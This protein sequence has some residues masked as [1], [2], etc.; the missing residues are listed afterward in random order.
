MP[1]EA[2]GTSQLPVTSSHPTGSGRQRTFAFALLPLLIHCSPAIADDNVLLQ[3]NAAFLQ[4]V[5]NTRLPPPQV[6]RAAAILHTCTYDAW[7]AYDRRALGTRFGGALRRPR[8][9]R[10]EANKS[11]AISF[12][13][14]RALGDLFPTQRTSVFDPLLASL[15][16]EAAPRSVDSRSP[17]YIG[18]LACKAVLDLRHADGANQLGD[19][20]P[21]AYSDYT[22]YRPINDASRLYDPNRWQPLLQSNGT[23]Q[24][25]L[26]PHWSRVK[27]FALAS[28]DQFR[29]PNPAFFPDEKYQ[30]QARELLR[31]S[32]ALSDRDKMIVS[33]WADGPGSETPP[34]HWNLLAQFVSRRDH[35]ALDDDVKMF[36][37]LGNAL[38]DASIAAWDAKVAF[39]YV[40]PIS[41]IRYLF[42]GTL[43]KAW[44]GPYQGTQLIDGGTWQPYIATPPFAEYVSGHSTF[45]AAAAA[46]LAQFTGSQRFG[47]SVTLPAGSSP[48]E[49]GFVPAQDVT[50]AWR[51]FDDAADQAGFSR[52]LGGIHFEDG[53]RRART[54][55]KEVGLQAWECAQRLFAGNRRADGAVSRGEASK[56][57]LCGRS[58]RDGSGEGR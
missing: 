57:A 4:A 14:Y 43:V 7:A 47:A 49:A 32:A 15:G 30:R 22:G 31:L 28:A 54:I 12:A 58:D 37:A 36:F 53:D 55:G 25:F 34:G 45:S 41:A 40:R 24:V 56:Q 35:H 44:A 42:G 16:Y 19:L 9:D 20:N 6:A 11:E 33:Y 39:D 3:W 29:P 17:A 52:R 50:L 26:V 2:H 18:D 48:I 27:P 13:A 10:T 8:S 1:N 46:V 38:L 5:R 21:G 23:A 51:T